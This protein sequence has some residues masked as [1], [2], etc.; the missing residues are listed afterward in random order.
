MCAADWNPEREPAAV[1]RRRFI[2][3]KRGS[4]PEF[5]SDACGRSAGRARRPAA[6]WSNGLPKRTPSIGENPGAGNFISFTPARRRALRAADSNR[7]RRSIPA[8]AG[9]FIKKPRFSART[10]KFGRRRILRLPPLMR[11][12]WRLVRIGRVFIM[13]G[14]AALQVTRPCRQTATLRKKSDIGGLMRC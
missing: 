12:S 4:C 9:I 13:T 1:S 5:A 2:T 14:S 8:R 7:N 6:G 3:W 11:R 10:P